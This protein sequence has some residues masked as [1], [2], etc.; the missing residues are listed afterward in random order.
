[1]YSQY[2]YKI[3]TNLSGGLLIGILMG[4]GAKHAPILEDPPK[5]DSTVHGT[6]L[7]GTCRRQFAA[8]WGL[9]REPLLSSHVGR[10]RT[11][12]QRGFAPK[13]VVLRFCTKKISCIHCIVSC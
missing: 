7:Y 1:M 9:S 10:E 11:R 3:K 12:G 4:S 5:F 13:T 8:I 2:K 6:K